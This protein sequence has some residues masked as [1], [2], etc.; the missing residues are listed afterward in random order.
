M[1]S[2]SIKKDGEIYL[3]V[4]DLIGL[5]NDHGADVITKQ[6]RSCTNALSPVKESYMLAHEHIINLLE[7]EK[8]YAEKLD[9]V[10]GNR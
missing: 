5:I 4:D 8:K 10:G 6:E 3:N 1:I 7:I 2:R 9:K